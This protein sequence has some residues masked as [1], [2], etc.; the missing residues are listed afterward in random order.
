LTLLDLGVRN[1]R[2]SGRVRGRPL[3]S[4]DAG[5][6]QT[7]RP[8]GGLLHL[9]GVRGRRRQCASDVL[10][11]QRDASV[12][13]RP[14]AR[15]AVIMA[16][17][18]HPVPRV[19]GASIRGDRMKRVPVGVQTASTDSSPP[20]PPPVITTCAGPRLASWAAAL[21]MSEVLTTGHPT[22]ADASSMLGVTTV[23][24]GISRSTAATTPR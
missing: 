2:S 24:S 3:A 4:P 12:A 14:R 23:T 5:R 20:S 21:A 18:M 11:G 13:P 15:F 7:L 17:N 22:S 1:W 8:A 10:L 19:F 9:A 6:R 16:E